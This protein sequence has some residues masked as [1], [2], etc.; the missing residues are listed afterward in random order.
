VIGNLAQDGIGRPDTHVGIGPAAERHLRRIRARARSTNPARR[1]VEGEI[2]LTGAVRPAPAM[3][4]RLSA[5][6]AAGLRTV[7]VPELVRARGELRQV[8][9]RHVLDALAWAVDAPP[10]GSD[11]GAS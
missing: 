11:A 8:P 2:G 7:F 1:A 3:T 6:E 5:A 4:S 9:V 10:S